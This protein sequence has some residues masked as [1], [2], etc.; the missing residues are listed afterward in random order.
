MSS[1][2]G[3]GGHAWGC[4]IANNEP[5]AQSRLGSVPTRFLT[6]QELP[7]LLG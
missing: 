5:A 4:R 7:R 3:N 2:G 1:V 6:D